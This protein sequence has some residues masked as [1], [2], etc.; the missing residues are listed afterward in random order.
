MKDG[1]REIVITT[2]QEQNSEEITLLVINVQDN[3]TGIAED[4]LQYLFDPFFTT[5][6]VGRGT[7]L[8]LF[9]CHILME[10]LAGTITLRN[11]VAAGVE[12]RITL[13]LHKSGAL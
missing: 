7:G 2:T 12:V 9:V 13:P 5:K 1:E 10:S 8:G 11:R 3:G 6:E 4:Q